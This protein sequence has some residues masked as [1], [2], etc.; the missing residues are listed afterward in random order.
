MSYIS[1]FEGFKN[2]I[3]ESS[4][5]V[6]INDIKD[7]KYHSKVQDIRTYLDRGEDE[8]DRLKKGLP[9]FTPSGVFKGGRKLENLESYSQIIVLDFDKIPEE[10]IFEVSDRAKSLQYTKACFVSPSNKGLKVFVEVTSGLEDHEEA[11]NQVADY[12]EKE[13]ELPLDR[14]GKDV[15]R[16]CFVSYDPFAYFTNDNVRFE[17]EES[18]DLSNEEVVPAAIKYSEGDIELNEVFQKCVAFTDKKLQYIVGQRNN[19][20]HQ[21]ACNCNRSGIEEELALECI[22]EKYDLDPKEITSTVRTV[23]K[24]HPD[25][26]AQFAQFARI[27]FENSKEELIEDELEIMPSIPTSVYDNLPELLKE[28]CRVFDGN[29]EKDVFLTGG[30]AILSGCLT[31]IKGTYDQ[32][33]VY[34]NL[35]CF[36]IAP[37]ASGKGEMVF[38]RMLGQSFHSKL[39]NQSKEDLNAYEAQMQEFK[40]QQK[41]RKKN[42]PPLSLDEPIKPP[43][44][45]L[46]IPGNSSS[47]AV[48]NH[49]NQGEGFGIFC[50]TEADTI[51]N[52]FKQDWG[53]FSDLLRKAFHHENISYS[54]KANNEYFEID[55]PKLSVA[56]SGTPS[57][58]SKII[59]SAEDGMFS[60]FIFYCFKQKPEWRDV[61]PANNKV[62]LT[63]HFDGLSN[64]VLKANEFL[65]QYPCEFVLTDKQWKLLQDQ[66]KKWLKEVDV[67]V[68]EEAISTVRRLGL[69]L[70]R[71]AMILTGLRKYENK[72]TNPT[73]ACDDLDFD[74]AFKLIE[75]YKVHAIEMFRRLPKTVK[76]IGDKCKQFFYSLPKAFQRKEALELGKSLEIAERTVDKFLAKLKANGYLSIPEYGQ[77]LKV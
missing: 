63:D 5:D 21:L 52:T 72:N 13:M 12:Y 22:L 25:Q 9:A 28:G 20:I 24:H 17:V 3:E 66:F 30:L 68:G 75:V 2:P 4:L 41:S 33:T 74:I 77:Y 19:Y 73:I 60:R 14:S 10:D 58:V 64:Q 1:L 34:P 55:K 32:K 31:G 71:M 26:F 67:F 49:L 16:L 46:F 40:F 37:A 48:I 6:I 27:P 43:F 61:S 15:N 11:F 65:A 57:Q 38:S 69:I 18:L 50:E 45:L 76:S 54:R 62:N 47:A 56:L 8:A 70:Y 53:G 36:I 51:G 42:D 44:R 59:S 29:R 35:Y 39:L 23:Y 7:G